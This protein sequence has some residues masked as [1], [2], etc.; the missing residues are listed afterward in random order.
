MQKQNSRQWKKKKSQ[1]TEKA[2]SDTYGSERAHALNASQRAL[3]ARESHGQVTL[4][5]VW[6]GSLNKRSRINKRARAIRDVSFA[7]LPSCQFLFPSFRFFF[8]LVCIHVYLPI[9]CEAEPPTIYRRGGIKIITFP[10]CGSVGKQERERE[11][12]RE[13]TFDESVPFVRDYVYAM[14]ITSAPFKFW[15]ADYLLKSL[16]GIDWCDFWNLQLWRIQVMIVQMGCGFSWMVEC[17]W[18]IVVEAVKIFFFG[19]GWNIRNF[20]VE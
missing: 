16:A 12:G 4:S 7:Y 1:L 8:S 2:W 3:K 18:R 5:V 11:S 14:R 15:L 10:S 6:L 13:R 20:V 9:G 17:N 19:F